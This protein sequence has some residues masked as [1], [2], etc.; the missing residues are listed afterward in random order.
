M[1]A[2]SGMGKVNFRKLITEPGMSSTK[3]DQ[4]M[5]HVAVA[6]GDGDEDENE[7]KMARPP[8][9]DMSASLSP[10]ASR[11]RHRSLR[12][13]PA[14]PGSSRGGREYSFA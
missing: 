12:P 5:Q 4:L 13:R 11:M 3:V 8:P 14:Q 6:D 7:E 10:L 1:Y 2:K 9:L